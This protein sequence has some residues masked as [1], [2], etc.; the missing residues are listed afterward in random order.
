M[1]TYGIADCEHL[2]FTKVKA[3]LLIKMQDDIRLH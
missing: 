3:T 2:Q 1:T